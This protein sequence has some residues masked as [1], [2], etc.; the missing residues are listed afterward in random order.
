MKSNLDAFH[1]ARYAQNWQHQT[2]PGTL[3]VLGWVRV[4]CAPRARRKLE[5]G[6]LLDFA[7]AV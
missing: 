2:M 4:G 5:P 6:F 1:C 7:L 3:P